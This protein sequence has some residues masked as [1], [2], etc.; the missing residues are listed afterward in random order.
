MPQIEYSLKTHDGLTLYG[1]DWRPEAPSR[2]AI[3]LVHGLG[4]HIRRYDHVAAAM[5]AAGLGFIGFDL[6]GHGKSGGP[7]GHSPSFQHFMDD[8]GLFLEEAARRYPAQPRFLYGH[9]L[10]GL[11][12]LDYAFSCRPSLAGLVATG[13]ALKPAAPTSSLKIALGKVLYSMAPSMTMPNGLDL[14]SLSTDPAVSQA[15]TH[16]PLVHNKISARMGLDLLNTGQWVSQQKG[17]LPFPVL[18][19]HGKDDRITSAASTGEFARALSGDVTLKIWDG[20]V[21][22]IHNEVRKEEVLAYML[23]WITSHIPI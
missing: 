2:A 5:N 10:G 22:E 3:C 23:G 20:M 16:D 7:R 17:P 21:H 1:L 19:M 6:R 8:I 9:S 11:L 4:E 12:V 14:T 13:P 15:Y 18:L